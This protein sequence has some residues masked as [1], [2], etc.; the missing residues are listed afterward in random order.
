M[1]RFSRGELASVL[2]LALLAG[3][4]PRAGAQEDAARKL[5]GRAEQVLSKNCASCHA[6]GRNE[7]GLACV[8]DASRLVE[9]GL[10]V[11][12]NPERSEIAQVASSHPAVGDEKIGLSPGELG[13]LRA[14][15][16]AKAPDLRPAPEDGLSPAQVTA[17]IQ[18]SLAGLE[19]ADRPFA[20]FFS[21]AHL[22]RAGR[23]PDELACLRGGLS[24]LLASLSWTPEIQAPVAIDPGK[25]VQRIDLRHYGWDA[26]SWKAI[27]AL[28]PYGQKDGS[29]EAEAC[30]RDTGSELP[31]VRAD[32]FV[33]AASRAPLYHELLGLPSSED[34][35]EA[36]LEVRATARRSGFRASGESLQHRVVERRES[37]AGSYWKTYDFRWEESTAAIASRDIFARPASFERDGSEIIFRLPNGLQGYMATN[38]K[39]KRL[40]KAPVANVWNREA[41]DGPVENVSAI[42]CMACHVRGPRE[43]PKDEVR[44]A[45]ET[46]ARL[47]AKTQ[48]KVAS[49]YARAGEL[50]EPQEAD[51]RAFLAAYAKTG[52][53]PGQRT[54]PLVGL[55]REFEG[56]VSA[57]LAAAEVGVTRAVLEAKLPHAQLPD[58][59]PLARGAS[60]T[61]AVFEKNF[62][63]AAKACE[64]G[65]CLAFTPSP[66]LTL[67]PAP[68]GYRRFEAPFG[69]RIISCE[70]D[71]S[72]KFASRQNGLLLERA[73]GARMVFSGNRNDAPDLDYVKVED[74]RRFGPRFLKLETWDNKEPSMG[75]TFVVLYE[76]TTKGRLGFDVA[77]LKGGRARRG[78]GRCYRV[79]AETEA[80]LYNETELTRIFRTVKIAKGSE[81]LPDDPVHS[82]LTQKM[83]EAGF[84]S[85]FD[86][87][88]AR[89]KREGKLVLAFVKPRAFW[90]T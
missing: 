45:A 48:E 11:R 77:T 35:L 68:P 23:S 86:L 5:A 7:G 83:K 76:S 8:L 79:A 63:A 39:G 9:S 84:E 61:R 89:A 49:L 34:E 17:E 62:P 21:L 85:D 78:T 66:P 36:K 88:L 22:A 12:G 82:P 28:Y 43:V 60:V 53:R 46:N 67:L 25:M 32:W 20:R 27:V 24:F 10:L 33:W 73:D 44:P 19:A 38:A 13:D 90:F 50:D 29:A 70:Y 14:W 58:L 72:W 56:G 54:D 75:R 16:D 42:A 41:R 81:A 40:D 52:A 6:H 59:E 47:D 1:G 87:A 4:W 71:R 37:R 80:K 51:G 30:A 18:K 55:S 64:A 57:R 2:V 69:D 15:I 31:C 74:W 3:A 65:T 26:S